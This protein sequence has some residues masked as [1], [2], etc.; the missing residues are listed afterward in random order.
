MQLQILLFPNSEINKKKKKEEK[1]QVSEG[2]IY[3]LRY[4]STLYS[5]N[6]WHNKGNYLAKKGRG[7]KK[8]KRM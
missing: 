2:G 4:S 5:R 8:G 6:Y 3:E 1:R 7:K